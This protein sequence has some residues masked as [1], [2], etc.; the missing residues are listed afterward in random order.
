[1]LSEEEVERNMRTYFEQVY[2]I[3]DKHNTE[4]HY[5]S[6]WLRKLGFIEIGKMADKFGLH[7]LVSREL[8]KKRLDAGKRVSSRE[9]LYPLM[10]GYDSVA[11]KADVELGGMDQRFNLLAGRTIQP[12]YGQEPQ[13][14]VIMKFPLIGP[15]GR[16]MSSSWGNVINITDQPN[17]MFG[18]VMS[19]KDD[20]VIHYFDMATQLSQKEISEVEEKLK[21]GVNPKDIKLRL[22]EEIVKMYHGEKEAQK[23]KEE[24]ERVFSK[25]EKPED[26]IGVE[27]KGSVLQTSVAAGVVGSNTE[28]KHLIEQGA[29]KINDIVIE[30][31]DHPTKSGD[32]VQIGPRKFY[33]VK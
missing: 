1:M 27:N 30:K 20:L 17:N 23:A 18:K 16:K 5:N 32:I 2:K 25:G 12:L 9:N 33:K 4:T 7:E 10:Q 13:D 26:M 31:W 29:V 11:V 14:I 3:L 21:Q 19:I 6:R 8:I 24:W 28:F 22:A 15:D